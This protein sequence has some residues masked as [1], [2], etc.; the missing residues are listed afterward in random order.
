MKTGGGVL[1][2]RK[3][4]VSGQRVCWRKADEKKGKRGG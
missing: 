4:N 3:R 1:K 2:K